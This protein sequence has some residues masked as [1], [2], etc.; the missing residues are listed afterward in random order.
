MGKW[1]IT[2]TCALSL[3]GCTLAPSDQVIGAFAKDNA[4]ACLKITTIYG[5]VL[6]ARANPNANGSVTCNGDGL[7]QKSDGFTVPITVVPSITV[8][9]SK[10]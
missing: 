2:V 6:Y 9:P 4:S 10:P 8:S 1:A 7:S 3:A 5:T